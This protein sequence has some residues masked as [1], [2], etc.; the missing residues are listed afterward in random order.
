M[1]LP[2]AIIPLLFLSSVTVVPPLHLK[3]CLSHLLPSAPSEISDAASRAQQCHCPSLAVATSPTTAAAT[4]ILP[5]PHQHVPSSSARRHHR[6]RCLPLSSVHCSLTLLISCSPPT[7]TTVATI[8]RQIPPFP[9]PTDSR[10][11]WFP[12]SP[13]AA[14]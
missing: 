1:T 7:T 5:P 11:R 13:P 2:P 4:P 8:A 3:R 9:L 6:H 12:M 10:H 14:T